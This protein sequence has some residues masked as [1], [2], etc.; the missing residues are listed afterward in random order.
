[1]TLANRPRSPR[2]RHRARGGR[3]RAAAPRRGRLDRGDQV[4]DRRHRH[5]GRP[6]GRGAH[7]RATGRAS[8]P[9]TASSARSPAPSAAHRHHLGRR[10]DRR[11]R[12]LRVRHPGVRGEHRRGRAASP[13]PDQ[14][15]ALAGAVFSPATGELFHAAH[16]ERRLAAADSGSPS[17]RSRARRRPAGD[18]VRLQPGDP[19]RR[20]RPRRA[21]HADGARSA[22]HRRGIASTS[23][24]SPP[25]G[26]TATS[27]AAC[28]RGTTRPA[29]CSSP[30]PAGASEGRRR[31]TTCRTPLFVAA[32]P[33]LF[34]GLLAA[35]LGD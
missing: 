12:Q 16:G 15:E 22:A 32:G 1:M 21:R 3:A 5:R 26:S 8:G 11:H 9:A 24:M 18:R 25:G 19:R 23:P 31:R 20:P 13:S 7:P 14:W 35:A 34:D 29:R 4:G 27:S 10:P 17:T 33:G 2:H 6:R 28:S 30:R